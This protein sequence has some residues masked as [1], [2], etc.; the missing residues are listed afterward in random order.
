MRTALLV[1]A[2]L[3]CTCAVARAA[4]RFTGFLTF[5]CGDSYF[6]IPAVSE[7]WFVDLP[8]R[9]QQ[10]IFEAANMYRDEYMTWWTFHVEIEGRLQNKLK[11]GYF[12]DHP[13][14]LIVERIVAARYPDVGESVQ[15]AVAP[16]KRFRGYLILGEESAGF[17]PLEQGREVWWFVQGRVGWDQIGRYFPKSPHNFY[18]VLVEIVGR[19][20]PPGAY[21]HLQSFEREIVMDEFTHIRP[22]SMSE[23]QGAAGV[24]GPGGGMSDIGACKP[25]RR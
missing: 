6:K 22:S 20:G 1:V 2:A 13:K 16:A 3:A 12:F 19:V 4:E 25:Q 24:G 17:S 8:A 11:R 5:G 7:T 15:A 23:L 14:E 21:G 18:I 9:R 10:Q